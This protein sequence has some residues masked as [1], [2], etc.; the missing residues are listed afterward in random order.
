MRIVHAPTDLGMRAVSLSAAER[1]L[2][3]DTTVIVRMAG[4]HR[5]GAV[6]ELHSDN[7][8]VRAWRML[9]ALWTTLRADLIILNSG[10]SLVDSSRWGLELLDL[11]LYRLLRKRVVMTYQGCDVRMCDGCPVREFIPATEICVNVPAGMGYDDFDRAKQRRLAR[12]L[13]AATLLQGITP[14]LCRSHP[15]IRYSPHVKSLPELASVPARDPGSRLR[16]AHMPKPH[17]KGTPFIM[18]TLAKLGNDIEIILIDG[19]PWREAL[20]AVASCDLVVDQVLSGWYGGISVE[21]ALLGVPS[22]ARI[23]SSLLQFVP[24]D[25]AADLPVIALSE[26]TDLLGAVTN[27]VRDRSL[28]QRE[29]DRCRRSALR[30]HD[31]VHIARGI[32]EDSGAA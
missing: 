11:R 13:P 10:T 32:L 17:I 31:A 21:A 27:L 26:R 6:S 18:D 25:M 9:G 1:S 28:L 12:T 19:M 29:A 14:D 4:V 2:G 3:H 16:I 20:S 5:S 7:P 30:F 15:R 24:Q 8:L 22:I 23:D